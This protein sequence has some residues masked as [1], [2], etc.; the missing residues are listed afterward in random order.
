MSA[1]KVFISRTKEFRDL[2][3]YQSA[4]KD[5]YG[6][7]SKLSGLSKFNKKAQGSG[8]KD[9]KFFL[10]MKNGIIGELQLN[11]SGML[12]AKEK[13][14]V[15]YDILRDAKEGAKTFTIVNKDVLEKVK[16]HMNEGWFQFIDTRIPSVKPQL[17][18]VRQMLIRLNGST[19]SSLTVSETESEALKTISLALYAQ[20]EN[21][22]ALL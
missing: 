15:I 4:L 16:H 9:I 14:H 3:H 19:V 21:G 6:L 1:A 22:T 13:E 18:I 2:E 12:V 11:I 10:K 5:R 7:G 17:M 8:Y 20:G